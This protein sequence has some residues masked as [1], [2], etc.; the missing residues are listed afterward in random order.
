M[1]MYVDSDGYPTD[2]FRELFQHSM[3]GRELLDGAAEYFNASGY[4][5]ADQ[6]GTEYRFVT[7]GWSGCE[8]VINLLMTNIASIMLWESSHRGGL[9]VFDTREVLP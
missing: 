7:G 3:S 2:E 9:H 8:E 5:K 1:S 4:G 6:L